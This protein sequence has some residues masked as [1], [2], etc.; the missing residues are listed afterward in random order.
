[1]CLNKVILLSLLLYLIYTIFVYENKDKYVYYVC[2]YVYIVHYMVIQSLKVIIHLRILAFTSQVCLVPCCS[3]WTP[4][5]F[6]HSTRTCDVPLGTPARVMSLPWDTLRGTWVIEPT[7]KRVCTAAL[8][9][10]MNKHTFKYN[11]NCFYKILL[12]SM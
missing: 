4:I 6:A 1:M 3:S 11:R 2:M 8:P 10:L 7:T 12:V 5:L 9:S